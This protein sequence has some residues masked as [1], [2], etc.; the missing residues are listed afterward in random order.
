MIHHIID[1]RPQVEIVIS[2]Y[3]Y[4]NFRD[5]LNS[6]AGIAVCRPL[7]QSMGSPTPAR[8]TKPWPISNPT[9]PA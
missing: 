3:D 8:S 4:P 9:W 5:T 1:T 6:L 7:H 2:L